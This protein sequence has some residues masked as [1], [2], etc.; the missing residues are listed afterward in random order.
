MSHREV[1]DEGRAVLLVGPE[2]DTG[3]TGHSIPPVVAST[4]PSMANH[5]RAVSTS[6][7]PRP[8]TVTMTT[9]GS[10]S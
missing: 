7:S 5:F 8:D 6:L 4:L 1:T 2:V 9:D 3:A 10:P